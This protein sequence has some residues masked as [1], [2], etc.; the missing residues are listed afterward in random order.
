[1]GGAGRGR[2]ARAAARRPHLVRQLARVAQH[3]G[4]HLGLV[5]LHLDLLQDGDHKHRSLA[6]AGLGLA[7]HV[8]PHDRLGDA[9]VLDCRADGEGG[10]WGSGCAGAGARRPRRA[11]ARALSTARRPRR[12]ARA[13][14]PPLFRL[15]QRAGGPPAARTLAGVLKAAVLDSLDQLGLRGRRGGARAGEITVSRA[16]ARC[17]AR[18]PSA[19]PC[20][21]PGF[22]CTLSRK[23]LKDVEWIPT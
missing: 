23:S 5:V 6:H 9:L 12:T 20:V 2:A 8:V 13:P 19:A 10:G 11:H 7:Q 4:E 17:R 22:R 3:D 21:H 18:T 16:A 14:P 1:M 15:R